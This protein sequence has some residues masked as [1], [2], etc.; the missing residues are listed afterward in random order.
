VSLFT[1]INIH[2]GNG[3][4]NYVLCTFESITVIAPSLEAKKN[5]CIFCIYFT[6]LTAKSHAELGDG[7]NNK[8]HCMSNVDKQFQCYF[9]DVDIL[10]AIKDHCEQYAKI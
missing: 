1:Y 8:H 7:R 9:N 3:I 2:Y 5:V 4:I 10:G 6:C